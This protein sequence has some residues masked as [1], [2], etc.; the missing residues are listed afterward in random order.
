MSR[1]LRCP[2]CG[3]LLELSPDFRDRNA[4]CP[5]CGASIPASEARRSGSRSTKRNT[6]PMAPMDRGPVLSAY[7]IVGLA[8]S[9]VLLT[10][11]FLPIVRVPLIGAELFSQWLGR[12]YV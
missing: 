5:A 9:A 10:G 7:Q 8:G 11:A 6:P 1:S 4:P 2:S 12:R 3:V